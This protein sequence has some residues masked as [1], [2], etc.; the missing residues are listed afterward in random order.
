MFTKIIISLT[1][2]QCINGSKHKKYKG[3]HMSTKC[4]CCQVKPKQSALKRNFFLKNVS[5][6]NCFTCISNTV[7]VKFSSSQGFLPL[8]DSRMSGSGD[9]HW[10]KNSIFWFFVAILLFQTS[11]ELHEQQGLHILG[12]TLASLTF[13]LPGMTFFHIHPYLHLQASTVII[14]LLL[15]PPR[16]LS[17]SKNH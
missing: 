14:S 4:S 13:Q 3:F 2:N 10:S 6:I 9:A 8:T 7:E 12:S 5:S 1:E 17:S 15:L 11:Q 16:W